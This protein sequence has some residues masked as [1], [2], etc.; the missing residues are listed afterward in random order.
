MTR[1]GATHLHRLV[2]FLLTAALLMTTCFTPAYAADIWSSITL[3]ILWEDGGM[4]R[5]VPAQ[6]VPDSDPP[7][8]WANV[9]ASAAGQTLTVEVSCPDP[10]YAFYLADATLTFPWQM[11]APGVDSAYAYPIYYAVDGVQADM[12]IYLYVS[13]QALPEEEEDVFVPFTVQVPVYYLTDSGEWL[14]SQVV[15]CWAG[16]STAVW[17]ASANTDGYELTSADTVQVYVDEAGT[18]TPAEVI[19]T[20]AEIATPTP[21]PTEEPTPTPIP[22]AV[23][24]VYYY[25]VNGTLLDVQEVTLQPGTHT[26]T[27]NSGNVADLVPVGDT[28]VTVNVYA[29]GSADIASVTFQYEDPVPAEAIIPV[30]YYH[31]NGNLLDMQEVTLQ[32]GSHTITANSGNVADLIPVGDTSVTVTVYA[33]GSADIASVTFQYEDPAPAEAVIPV[34]YYHVNG[35]LLDVQEVTL[36]PG[37]HTITANS[38]NVADLVPVGDTYVTVTV[39]ADGSA[40]IASVTFQYEDPAP[41]EAIIPVYYY[42]VNGTL[43]DVQEVTLQPGTHTITANSG[44]VADLIPVGDTSVTVTVYADGSADIASVTFQYED[45]APA[46]AIIPIYYYHINGTLLDMQ[47]VTLQPGTHTITANSGNVVDLIPVGDTAVTVT[48]YADGSADIAS[49]TFQYEDPAPVEAIIP[50]YY[51]HVNGTLLDMQEVTLQPGSHTI[52]ANSDKVADLVLEGAG[53]AEVTVYADGSASLASVQFLYKSA[54]KEPVQAAVT[55]KYIHVDAG[56]IDSATIVLGEG[57]HTV[58]AASSKVSG[59]LPLGNTTAQVTVDAEGNA[60]PD[61]VEFYYEDAYVAPVTAEVSVLYQTAEG[62]PITQETLTLTPGSHTVEPDTGMLSTLG[63]APVGDQSQLVVVDENGAASPASV[64]FTCRNSTVKITVYYQ[65]DRGRDVAPAQEV[66]FTQ[67]GDY[68]IQ[69]TPADLP[70]TYELAPGQSSQENVSVVNGTASKTEVYFYYQQKQTTPAVANVT[71]CYY[72]PYGNE[73]APAQTITLEPGIHEVNA[74]SAETFRG[75]ELVSEPT[76][77]VEVYE[78][79]TFSPQE[80]A[81]YYRFAETETKTATVKVYYRDDRGIDVATEQTLSLADGTHNIQAE[82]ADLPEGYVIFP[83][84]DSEVTITVTDGVASKSQ[85]VFYYQKVTTSTTPSTF[86]IP[87]YYYDTEG[88]IVATTQYVQVGAGTYA[89]QPNP[90]DLPAGYELMMDPVLT[91]T[92]YQDGTTDPEEIAFY[93]LAPAK[94]ATVTVYYMSEDGQYLVEPFDIELESGFNT[95]KVDAS[96]VPSTYDPESADPVNVYVSRE[97]V[98]EPAQVVFTFEALIVETPIPV[99]EYVYRY[100]KVTSKSVAFRSEPSTSGGNKTVIKRLGRTDEVYVLQELYNDKNEL[101]AM[102]NVDGR[103][104]YMMSEFLSLMT[105]EESDAYAGDNTPVPTFTPEPTYTPYVTATPTLEPLPTET[106][107]P[108]LVEAIT[109]EPTEVPTAEPT[110]TETATPTASP[111]PTATPEPYTGYALTTRATALRTGISASDMTI[112]HAMEANTLVHVVNQITDAS[113]GEVWSIISTLNKQAGYV[114]DSSLRYISD[115]DAQPYLDLWEA[116]NSEPEPTEYISPTPEPMQLEGYGVVLGDGVPFRQ[117]QSEYSRII[118]NLDAGTMVYISGQTAGEGQYWHSVNYEGRWGY[119]RTDLVRMLTIAEEEEY[120]E[121]LMASPTPATT[122]IP[123]DAQGLSSYGYVDGSNV[124][125]REGP[126]TSDKK[127]GELRRYAFCLVLGTEYVNG[128]T[129]YRV[130]YGEQTGYI[131]G[132]FFKQMTIA[133]LEDFLGSEEYLQGVVNNSTDGDAALDNVGYTGTGGL[134]SAEDQWVHDNTDL[135]QNTVNPWQPIATVAPIATATPTLEPLP[136]AEATETASPSPTPTFNQMPDVTYPTSDDGNG[137]SAM[138]WVFVIGLLLLAGGG[139]FALVR[140]QQNKRRIAMRAAQ[141][142]AQA[143]RAQQQQQRPYARTAAQAQPRTGTYP[144]Q[145]TQQVQQTQVRRPASSGTVNQS[146][147]P[148]TPYARPSNYTP[149]DTYRPTADE[150]TQ[151]T[152]PV[153]EQTAP[154][155]TTGTTRRRR[156]EYRQAQENNQDN[157]FDA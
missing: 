13:S 114:L 51:Y 48:V 42:H 105:Q 123:F 24:P 16:E 58:E 56:L 49:V 22:E 77:T 33:D 38:S 9:D 4:T 118:D 154:A 8:Y 141:R 69:A 115:K 102:V 73:I 140:Y 7:A 90:A 97:G 92:V 39:Y 66:T 104:G 21:E 50:V 155:Q 79:G 25:H 19:F 136:G 27:A 37:S 135:I 61:T 112:I 30:Y 106:A 93:Y 47:E 113:T 151:V 57:V 101:W 152:S 17:A 120:L 117:M 70:D 52:T 107:T 29:D 119:I 127:I 100:A 28:S 26:I 131:H 59:Y 129:W 75:Y 111:T 145:Q 86:T 63:Y 99:G 89:I 133:E 81:F 76:I 44:N 96:R 87:V 137:G 142:R 134:V 148:Y 14:D 95:V 45:P 147:T 36:Q 35:T 43:L 46:E 78:N 116:Q 74:K 67:D 53:T 94:N 31:I 110:P 139:V 41:A 23:I 11:D 1:N 71:V 34:Y 103:I 153:T 98:A 68:T 64:L 83:G 15:E 108:P 124:N 62:M 72:D 6:P 65:D 143:A 32:P 144:N 88:K 130:K 126:S 84:T 5:I 132:D 82:P 128:V 18:A 85:V 10:S 3:S 80:V 138:V 60:Q 146:T 149:A 150:P 54:E 55:V 2:A 122:N 156:T 40:D 20:Y 125:W 121:S 12:P 91:V 157:T 109:P